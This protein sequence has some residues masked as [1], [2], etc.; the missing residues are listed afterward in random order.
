MRNDIHIYNFR[1]HLPIWGS[2]YKY[3]MISITLLVNVI[4]VVVSN[5]SKTLLLN[6]PII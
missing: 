2:M 1:H 3:L 6:L 4:G 5:R